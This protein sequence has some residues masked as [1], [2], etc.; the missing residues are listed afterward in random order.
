MSNKTTTDDFSYYAVNRY[1]NPETMIGEVDIII[2]GITPSMSV[3]SELDYST[4]EKAFVAGIKGIV[5]NN[6][7]TTAGR[8]FGLK[9]TVSTI[10]VVDAEKSMDSN[11]NGKCWAATASNLLCLTGW[12]TPTLTTED[13]I[14]DCYQRN[15][16]SGSTIGGSITDGVRWFLSGDYPE[17]DPEIEPLSGSTVGFFPSINVDSYL[18]DYHST[19][20]YPSILTSALSELKDG[21]SVGL[22]ICSVHISG[23]TSWHAVTLQGYTYETIIDTNNNDNTREKITGI[24]IANSDDD[25]DLAG[26]FPAVAPNVLVVVPIHFILGDVFLDMSFDSERLNWGWSP[27]KIESSTILKPAD[28]SRLYSGNDLVS[29]AA[30]LANKKIANGESMDVFQYGLAANTEVTFGGR[31][32]VYTGGSA[33]LVQVHG[34]G[35]MTVS[36]AASVSSEVQIGGKMDV[37]TYANF[38]SANVVYQLDVNTPE[39]DPLI[40]NLSNMGGVS[41]IGLNV[42]QKENFG[43]YVLAGS[44]GNFNSNGTVVVTD[45]VTNSNLA[46]L[47]NGWTSVTSSTSSSGIVHTYTLQYSGGVMTLDVGGTKEDQTTPCDLSYNGFSDVVYVS[48]GTEGQM[49]R[50]GLDGSP[51]YQDEG[52]LDSEVRIIGGYDMDWNHK[53][54]LVTCRTAEENSTDYLVVEYAQSGDLNDTHE[55]DRIDNSGNVDWNIYCGNLAGHEWKNSILWHAPDLGSLGF[56][57]DAGGNNSWVTIGTGY[58]YEWEVLGLGDFTNDSVHRDSVL[59]KYGTETIAEVTATNQYRRLGTLDSGWNIVTIGDFSNDGADDLILYNQ[60]TGMVGKWADGLDTGWSSL[61]TVGT[62]TAIEGAGDY[63]GDG[64]LDLLARQSDGT[65]GYY[66]SANLSQF[67]SFGYTMDSSWTVIA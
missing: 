33:S 52:I 22:G 37:V 34:G 24:I 39:N 58:D 54:D 21:N 5:A 57:A 60:S 13:E 26:D 67:T 49:L 50:Y 23:D 59:F 56:W 25:R 14:F 29:S 1:L 42:T 16:I 20:G 41:T 46:T 7:T 65:M 8:Y 17:D 3:Y 15:F 45:L 48:G 30:S 6:F 9:H 43:H 55:I 19:N 18:S 28:Y 11:A 40:T 66:A 51:E 47:S 36:Y 53:V 10:N 12:L 27:F 35:E 4:T 63:N 38:S 32:T 2:D 31:M 61:G 64:S 44:G 62:G